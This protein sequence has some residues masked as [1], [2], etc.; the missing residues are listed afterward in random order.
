MLKNTTGCC[1]RPAS[2]MPPRVNGPPATAAICRFCCAFGVRVVFKATSTVQAGGV[3]EL[4]RQDLQRVCLPGVLVEPARRWGLDIFVE[5]GPGPSIF[6]MSEDQ[7][8]ALNKFSTTMSRTI[9][10]IM[11]FP[12][13][14]IAGCRFCYAFGAR[15]DRVVKSSYRAWGKWTKLRL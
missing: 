3:E 1:A 12:G 13:G 6:G 10:R 11:C 7:W 8:L 5:S 15:A 14:S 4:S 2:K 9:E